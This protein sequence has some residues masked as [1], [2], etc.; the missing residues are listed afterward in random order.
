MGTIRHQLS[1]QQNVRATR[2]TQNSITGNMSGDY[3]QPLCLE[4][5]N[6][7][8]TTE[9]VICHVFDVDHCR[10]Q[11]TLKAKRKQCEVKQ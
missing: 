10:K 7:K 11:L 4:Y 3:T 8:Q 6:W 2:I 1:S 9:V 5:T